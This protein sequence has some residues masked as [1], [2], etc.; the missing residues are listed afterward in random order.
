MKQNKTELKNVKSTPQKTMH[1]NFRKQ[2]R[3]RLNRPR[4]PNYKAKA[5]HRAISNTVALSE[6]DFLL[7]FICFSFS[8]WHF[9]VIPVKWH[10]NQINLRI[11]IWRKNHILVINLLKGRW[12]F[13]KRVNLYIFKRNFFE[14]S[15]LTLFD[16]IWLN[17]Y[18]TRNII[19]G[20]VRGLL[21]ISKWSIFD[22]IWGRIYCSF[23]LS[24][25]QMSMLC[26]LLRTAWPFIH[27]S[28]PFVKSSI[29][30][31]SSCLIWSDYC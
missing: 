16:R 10:F 17:F 24:Q 11:Y 1:N 3:S 9:M 28:P 14:W 27:T 2:Y 8:F 4:L 21:P 19:S 29:Y 18:E 5:S 31:D 25:I 7:N 30:D 20:L 15:F 23:Y 26:D 12:S 13:L 6:L 22:W